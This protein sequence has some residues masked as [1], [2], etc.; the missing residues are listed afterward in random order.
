MASYC[1][2]RVLFF[3]GLQQSNAFG[4][5]VLLGDA[6]ESSSRLPCGDKSG[7]GRLSC[8]LLGVFRV[9]VPG[10]K[11]AVPSSSLPGPTRR[12]VR[13]CTD[14]SGCVRATSTPCDLP[15]AQPSLSLHPMRFPVPPSQTSSHSTGCGT[16]SEEQTSA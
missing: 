3:L 14:P 4:A 12:W 5:V 9:L 15:P 1:H 16:T 7:V 6:T 10:T 11:A 8:V 2:L 13:S